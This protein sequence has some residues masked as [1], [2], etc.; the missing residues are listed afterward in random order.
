[1]E[2]ERILKTGNAAERGA[3]ILTAASRLKCAKLEVSVHLSW[4]RLVFEQ[5]RVLVHV[6][7]LNGE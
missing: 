2:N 6:Y 3:M 4:Q 1:V 7:L 5:L